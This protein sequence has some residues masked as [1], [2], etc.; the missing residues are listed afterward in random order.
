LQAT[1]PFA[2][3]A[4][5]KKERAKLD[6]ES[7]ITQSLASEVPQ[8][9]WY[10]NLNFLLTPIVLSNS[11]NIHFSRLGRKMTPNSFLTGLDQPPPTIYKP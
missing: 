6:K 3:G 1:N 8:V 7:S 5:G 9:D 10:N 4:K 11:T 2:Y